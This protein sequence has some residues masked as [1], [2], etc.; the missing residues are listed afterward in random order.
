M[1]LMG[2]GGLIAVVGGLLFVVVVIKAIA[3]RRHR[4]DATAAAKP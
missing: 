1:A 3:S 4:V 2:V